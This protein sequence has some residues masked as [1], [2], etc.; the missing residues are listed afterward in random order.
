MNGL[1]QIM[2]YGVVCDHHTYD[3]EA[4]KFL[5]NGHYARDTSLAIANALTCN[6]IIFRSKYGMHIMYNSPWINKK[7][8]SFNMECP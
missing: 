2:E 7:I 5:N 8:S 1:V 3:A 4:A 6:I